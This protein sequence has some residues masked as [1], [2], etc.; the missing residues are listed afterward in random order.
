MEFKDIFL[1]IFIIF[2]FMICTLVTYL[3]NGMKHIEDNWILYR[4]NPLIMPFAG[5]F[6]HDADKNFGVCVGEM[7]KDSMGIF[8]APITA[9]HHALSSGMGQLSDQ[10]QSIRKLQGSL[11][12]A[13]AGNFFSIFNIF[14]NIISAFHKFI[15]GFKDLLMRL[16]AVMATML[17]LLQGQG[18]VGES[19]VNGPLMEA[20]RI[21]SLGQ[22]K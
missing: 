5:Y 8:L 4:C 13:M 17:Y 2:T 20:I 22:I 11:R 7:Q 16:L 10:M 14:G 18:M 21:L 19:V 15:N 3:T 6:G 1:S 9:G 12:P